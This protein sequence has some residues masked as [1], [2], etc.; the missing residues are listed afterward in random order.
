MVCELPLRRHLV[1]VL[2]DTARVGR[3]L[4]VFSR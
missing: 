1:A 2:M 3:V 4:L